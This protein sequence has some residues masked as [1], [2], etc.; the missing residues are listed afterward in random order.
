MLRGTGA[1]LRVHGGTRVVIRTG[2]VAL[3]IAGLAAEA[4]LAAGSGLPRTYDVV[5][6]SSPSPGAGGQYPLQLAN[7]GDLDGDGK[8]DFITGQL[9]NTRNDAGV[10]GAGGNGAA[11]IISGATGERIK[12]IESPDPGGAGNAANFAFPWVSKV[13]LNRKAPAT[14]T[15]MGSCPSPPPNAGE[16]CR[17]ATVGGPDGVPDILVGAR[18]VDA[19]G[20]KDSGRVYVFDG[21]TF[22]LLKRIDQPASD[23]TDV[24][25]SRAGGSWFG[26]VV[27]NPAGQPPC[28]GN[29]GVGS[30][31]TMAQS[32]VAGDVNGGGAPDLVIS[33]SATTENSATA[34]PDSHCA[35]TPD[36]VCGAA[37]RVYV[38]YGENIVGSSPGEILDGTVAAGGTAESVTT[39]RNIHAQAD[40]IRDPVA[41]DSEIFGNSLQP[42]GDVGECRAIAA[43]ETKPAVPVPAAGELCPRAQGFTTPDGRPEFLLM[44]PRTDLPVDA[45]DPNFADAGTA[46]LIDGKTSTI[47]GV[48][49]N[50]EPQLAAT[51]GQIVNTNAAGDLGDIGLPD[52]FIGAGGQNVPGSTGAGRGYVMN[53]NFKAGVGAVLIGRLDDPT[54]STA[55][56]FGRAAS[57]VG[58]LVPGAETPANEILVG[59]GASRRGIVSDVHF[60]NAATERVLQTISDPDAQAASNFGG[61][62][63]PLGDLNDDTF[64]DFAI[65]SPLYDSPTFTDEG[66]VYIFR[67]NNSPPP[68][69]PAPPA[70]PPAAAAATPPP[71]PPPP[72]ATVPTAAAEL[73][74][75]RCANDLRGTNGN[76]SLIG[77]I[78]GDTVFSLDGDDVVDSLSGEDCVNAGGD[79][80]N[81][82]GGS[83]NDSLLG[84]FGKDKL[85]GGS[86]ADRIFGQAGVDIL[87]GGSG[88]DMLAGGDGSD[89]L[90]G[91]SDRDRLFGESGK[92]V[93]SGGTGSDTLDGGSGSDRIYSVDR[94]RDTVRCGTGF[95]RAIVDRRDRVSGCERVTRRR[96]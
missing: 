47:L 12:T 16:L 66:R 36:A 41:S 3:A 35:R 11:Y 57:G 46:Y 14:F 65:S 91:G 6:H 13:G 79:D 21:A 80:D 54:P 61:D 27:L 32:V 88:R 38:Y 53:G 75:G 33:A 28:E 95:D 63:I 23:T 4:S 49:R 7:A 55:G 26:R 17:S 84:G 51:F 24:A 83:G 74:R 58:D 59:G 90:R 8:E 44:S 77:T 78:A 25:L 85:D 93:L 15:D 69:P 40:P 67:S 34:H 2:C 96:P 86:G 30:C 43:T 52:V 20:R 9:V 50:P 71:P 31:D 48:Y 56:G 68:P 60:F 89:R 62:I 10:I 37:G 18:G 94:W 87:T 29:A 1:L 5:R 81:V 73:L 19:K 82:G 72:A 76:D 45:P 22:A 70:P 64:L 39:I 92:D 42:V